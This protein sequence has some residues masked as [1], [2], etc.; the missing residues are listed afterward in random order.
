MK[1]SINHE[2]RL[3]LASA[4]GDASL[5]DLEQYIS[6]VIAAGALP[7]RK[8]FNAT[9]VAP[10]ALRLA[11]LRAFSRKVLEL[12]KSGP[13]GPIAIVV[14]S[15]LEQEMAEAFGKVDAGRPLAI[16]SDAAKAR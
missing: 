5:A 10:G 2:D 16:F 4:E 9:Y 13:I 11:E 15:E 3:V 1:W 8:L 6:G 7:N 12:A 14:G